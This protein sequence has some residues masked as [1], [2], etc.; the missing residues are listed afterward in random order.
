M[1]L[2]ICLFFVTSSELHK[3]SFS[4]SQVQEHGHVL[5][6]CVRS[7]YRSPCTLARIL[8]LVQFENF[9]TIGPRIFLLNSFVHSLFFVPLTLDLVDMYTC[10][11][12]ILDIVGMYSGAF[13]DHGLCRLQQGCTSDTLGACRSRVLLTLDFVHLSQHYFLNLSFA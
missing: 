12:L 6:A 7:F 2:F 13:F 1:C 8:G 4:N 11:P 9:F 10:V 5:C 3:N